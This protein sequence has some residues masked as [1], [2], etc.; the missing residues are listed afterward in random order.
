MRVPGRG[1]VARDP[2]CK[3]SARA[4]LIK[5][6]S[7]DLRLA[8]ASRRVHHTVLEVYVWHVRRA[9]RESD[10]E[11][12]PAAAVPTKV[13]TLEFKAKLEALSTK[14]EVALRTAQHL[15]SSRVCD[16]YVVDARRREANA[17]NALAIMRGGDLIGG[18]REFSSRTSFFAKIYPASSPVA[19]RP[20]PIAPH[21]PTFYADFE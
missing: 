4:T 11:K 14:L 17:A 13:A 18:G 6:S 1:I 19:R 16:E 20:S 8:S 15:K 12:S 3:S 10:E 2:T 21:S 9:E 5:L 7:V